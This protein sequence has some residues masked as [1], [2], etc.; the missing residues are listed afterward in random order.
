LATNN[1]LKGI[2]S[3]CA[4]AYERLMARLLDKIKLIVG[5]QDKKTSKMLEKELNF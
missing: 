4:V 1:Q 5:N 2:T 3:H